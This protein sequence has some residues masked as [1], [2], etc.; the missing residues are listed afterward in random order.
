LPGLYRLGA[1]S[2]CIDAGTD[3]NIDT[4]IDGDARPMGCGF[5][6]GAD[7]SVDC[8]DC[9]GDNYPDDTCGGDDCD[10]SDPDSNP[11]AEEICD[12]MD[13][14]C[15]GILPDDE[16]DN[17]QDGWMICEGDCDDDDPDVNPGTV[18]SK[19]MGNCAD[20][21]DNDCDGSADA[22]PECQGCFINFVM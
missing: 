12:Y 17:D 20:G 8:H 22:D 10:D 13:N 18:E 6:M 14:D 7:E 3:A 5:D 16:A 19:D 4:D 1:N 2:P 9:D 11:E 15:D 21:I